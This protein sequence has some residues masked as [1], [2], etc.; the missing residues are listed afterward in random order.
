MNNLINLPII[1]Y[2]QSP[3]RE[4]F[5]IP[6]QPNLVS[7]Q[8]RIKMLAPYNNPL[9]FDGITHFSHLWLIWQFHENK[10]Q[11]YFHPQ[12]RPPRL[13]GNQKIGVFASRSM[14]RP[15][16]IGLSVVKFI[17][18]EQDAQGDLWLII[19]GADLVDGTPILDI[20][21]YLN[22]ADSIPLADSGYAQ[23]QPAKKQICWQDTQL[24]QH[25]IDSKQVLERHLHELEQI[26]AFDPRPAYQHDD[27]RLYAMRFANMDVKF[28]AN[29]THI[30]IIA[31]QIE[32]VTQF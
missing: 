27:E 26:L 30:I 7:V 32:K 29:A 10:N 2:I 18:I 25:L 31:I 17:A 13:G 20:K 11:Q 6:R 24:K 12:V 5:G 21:P 4:K 22:Y 8:S 14:Y 19:E 3:Y 16:P 1:A 23:Q 9:A 28:K 15:A